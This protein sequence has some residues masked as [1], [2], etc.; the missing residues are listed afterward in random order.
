MLLSTSRQY[1]GTEKHGDCAVRG[2]QV[3]ENRVMLTGNSLNGCE[4]LREV[5]LFLD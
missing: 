2:Y 1:T 3:Y 5:L 4:S